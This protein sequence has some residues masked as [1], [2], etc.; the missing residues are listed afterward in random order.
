M[1]EKVKV[2]TYPEGVRILAE[3]LDLPIAKDDIE[4]RE[5]YLIEQIIN[6]C[7]SGLY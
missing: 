5:N 7:M 1:S 2:N 4:A 3:K 6:F